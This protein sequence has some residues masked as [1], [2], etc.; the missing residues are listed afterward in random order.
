MAERKI[1]EVANAAKHY[2]PI[3]TCVSLGNLILPSVIGAYDV[4]LPAEQQG[5]EVQ[6]EKS[7]INMKNIIESAGGTLKNVG[8]VTVYISDFK[9]RELVNREWLKTFPEENRPARHIVKTEMP[10]NIWVQI[11]VIASL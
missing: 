4:T 2:N 10:A 6:I 7:F 9:H 5:P 1:V 3:P 11:D 8:K